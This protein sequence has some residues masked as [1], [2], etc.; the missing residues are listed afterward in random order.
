MRMNTLD[1]FPFDGMQIKRD[2][3]VIKVLLNGLQI[4]PKESLRLF[5]PGNKGLKLQY[6]RG[7]C[8][9]R[10]ILDLSHLVPKSQYVHLTRWNKWIRDSEHTKNGRYIFHVALSNKCMPYGEVETLIER[11]D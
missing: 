4:L 10:K 1:G 11:S 8:E 3:S 5:L 9:R 2:K 6:T 7:N